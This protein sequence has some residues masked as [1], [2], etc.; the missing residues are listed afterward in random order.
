MKTGTF[1]LTEDYVQ[2]NNLLKIVGLVESSWAW[3]EI[4][5]LGLVTLNGVRLEEMRKKLVSGD[6][7]TFED[8]AITVVAGSTQE[9]V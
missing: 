2:A 6:V 4:I 5:R 1:I 8:T 3:K 9:S 7:I